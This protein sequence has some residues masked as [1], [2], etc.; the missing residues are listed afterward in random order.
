MSATGRSIDMREVPARASARA[1]S[2]RLCSDAWLSI[3]AVALFLG[4]TFWWLTQDRSIPVFDAGVRLHQAI[5]VYTDLRSGDLG[6]AFTTTVPYPPFS[7]L[8]GALGLWLGGLGVAAPIVAANF[9]FVSLLALGCYNVGRLAFGSRAGLLA[10]VFALGSPLITA[11]FHVF[12]TDAPET[13]MVSVAVWLILASQR[14]SRIW[15]SALA[16]VAVGLGM[17]T[18]EPFAFFV[19][20]VVLVTLAR[21]GW[22]FWRGLTAFAIIT[23]LIALPWYVGEYSQLHELAQAVG[24]NQSAALGTAIAPH[25]WSIANLVWYPSNI[26]NTQLYAP[27][28]IFAAIGGIWTIVGIARR[29]PISPLSWEL[30][31][32]AFVGWL[33]IT[34]T[35]PHDPRY[36][37][38]LLLYLA[39]LGSG[40]IVRLSGMWRLTATTALVLTAMAN[41]LSTSFG[42]GG[43]LSVKLPTS[44]SRSLSMPESLIIYS[45]TGYLVAAPH[46]DGNLLGLMQALRR[47]GVREVQW[48]NLGHGEPPPGLTPDFSEAGLKAF[49]VIAGL[50]FPEVASS[51]A[52]KLTDRDAT[53]GHGPVTHAEAPPCVTLSDGTGV[54]VRLG[55]PNAPG[56]E[57]Y[58]P[59][60]R[61]AFY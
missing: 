20:G 32:G 17:L 14:F 4:I 33:G 8:V 44:I 12:M 40:W 42:L 37:M 10:V 18:K 48:I 35:F 49:A 61:S 22:R 55:N 56:V 7:Y 34:G 50:S 15:F 1:L 26:L 38:P 30:T 2:S 43:V 28:F 25:R 51:I 31:L 46:S 57:D 27:L 53:L 6:D 19:A 60:R 47:K 23:L 52:G 3:A 13:A 24:T 36:C 45:N 39:V 21:G 58:C 9:V 11:Q 29:H 16:G 41:T 5:I 54:W 59:F